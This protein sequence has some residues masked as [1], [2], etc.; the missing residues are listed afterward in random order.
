[1]PIFSILYSNDYQDGH[2][3]TTLKLTLRAMFK[4]LE[5]ITPNVIVIDINAIELNDFTTKIND[6]PWRWAN[7]VVG[8]E[9]IKCKLMLCW[10]HVKKGWM[11]YLVSDIIVDKRT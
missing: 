4:S 5:A 1:M 9:Q 10:F 3:A 6:K 11:K 8:G 7:N 2:K